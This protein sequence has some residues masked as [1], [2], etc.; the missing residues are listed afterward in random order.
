M[1]NTRVTVLIGAGSIGLAIARRISAGKHIVVADLKEENARA[2]ARILEEA[3]FSASHTVVDVGSKSSIQALVKNA[4]NYSGIFYL[5]H[6][7]GVS[8]SQAPKELILQVDLFGTA[9]ILE[10]FGTIIE[11]GGAGVIISSQSGY[12]LPALSAEED[13]WL[14]TTPADE[15]LMLDLTQ[16]EHIHDTLHAYQITKRGNGL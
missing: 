1:S 10:E 13:R 2:A 8:P 5:I 16:P 14:A 6:A 3:G 4:Q 7:A 9:V 12:R 15:L 11:Q